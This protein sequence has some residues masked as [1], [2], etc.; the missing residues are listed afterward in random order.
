VR[1]ILLNCTGGDRL[2]KAWSESGLRIVHD[3][4]ADTIRFEL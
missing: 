4:D 2:A 1:E 3:E